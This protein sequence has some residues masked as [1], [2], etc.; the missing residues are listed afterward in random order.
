MLGLEYKLP[1][2]GPLGFSPSE[3]E[4]WSKVMLTLDESG[5][6]VFDEDAIGTT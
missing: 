4:E 2:I 1:L 5:K 6:G 3:S